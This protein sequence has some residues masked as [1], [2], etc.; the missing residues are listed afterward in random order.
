AATW[1]GLRTITTSAGDSRAQLWR[2]VASIA[3]AVSL[4]GIWQHHNGY[5]A[6]RAEYT[7]LVDEVAE[8]QAIIAEGS[9]SERATAARRLRELENE[10][11]SAGIPNNERGRKLWES[12]LQASSEPVGLFAL[13]NTFAGFLLV[14][15]F[16]WGVSVFPRLTDNRQSIAHW[17]C[18]GLAISLIGYCLL[19]TKSRTAWG[20][21]LVVVVLIAITLR[22]RK[23]TTT[24]RRGLVV[25][26]AVAGLVLLLVSVAAL[27][28]GLDRFIL[29]EA[30][31]SLR[32]RGEYWVGT[33]R[34]LFDPAH[35]WRWVVGVGPGNFRQS[36]LPWKLPESSEEIADP[37]NLFFDHWSS[38]GLL[39]LIAVGALW[40]L[41]A[42]AIF[43]SRADSSEKTETSVWRI[44]RPELWGCVV[45]F[46]GLLGLSS[47]LDQQF[48]LLWIFGAFL[49]AWVAT[50]RLRIQEPASGFRGAILVGILVHL[51]AAGGIGMPAIVQLVMLLS[52]PVVSAVVEESTTTRKLGLAMALVS[53]LLAVLTTSYGLSPV[54]ARDYQIA[55]G[56]FQMGQ[57]AISKAERSYRQAM[58]S[59]SL[60]P[61]PCERLA[62]LA[63]GKWSRSKADS[64]FE[65]CLEFRKAAIDRNPGHAGGWRSLG[66]TWQSKFVATG[67]KQNATEAANAYAEAA[68]RHPTHAEI[69]AE[70]ATM[71]DAAG[72][73]AAAVEQADGALALEEINLR[74]GHID[75]QL[76]VALLEKMRKLRES[77]SP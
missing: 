11:L 8:L 39:G 31:K 59:D 52:L 53:A 77:P 73:H 19:L 69:L 74:F 10:M 35:P 26:A 65:R 68:T 30:F 12:R 44:N 54:I 49:V 45:S 7:R 27:T 15:L 70:W 1:F 57:G 67:D 28:G 58:D 56:D 47:D 16:A 48:Q 3:V 75:K 37:H 63:Q 42:R 51:L 46:A 2:L 4:L 40:L 64:D 33:W 24:S 50:G 6:A 9:R 29:L 34:M 61:L 25:A 5:S 32:Y 17:L 36:Y 72:N 43:S 71:L 14:G 23:R 76:P 13:A 21:S 20:G 60:A 55:E 38:G 62:G 41:A 66:E 18:F 22:F